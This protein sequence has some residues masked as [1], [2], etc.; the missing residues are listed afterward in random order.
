M[1]RWLLRT[2]LILLVVSTEGVAAFSWVRYPPANNVDLAEAWDASAISAD[3]TPPWV[4]GS[5]SIE[6]ADSDSAIEFEQFESCPVSRVHGACQLMKIEGGVRVHLPGNWLGGAFAIHSRQTST[7]QWEIRDS[8]N[9]LVVAETG[10][11]DRRDATFQVVFPPGEGL[12]IHLKTEHPKPFYLVSVKRLV[13][14]SLG[15]VRSAFEFDSTPLSTGNL[16][17]IVADPQNAGRVYAIQDDG[18]LLRSTDQGRSWNVMNVPWTHTL[19]LAIAPLDAHQLFVVAQEGAYY[20]SDRGV[21]WSAKLTGPI[22]DGKVRTGRERG[23]LQFS[24]DLELYESSDFGAS[25]SR[26]GT[27][28][29]KVADLALVSRARQS[30][31]RLSNGQ[32][33][34]RVPG[35]PW[36]PDPQWSNAEPIQALHGLSGC[37][38]MGIREGQLWTAV[39]TETPALPISIPDEIVSSVSTLGRNRCDLLVSTNKRLL[40]LTSGVGFPTETLIAAGGSI[41]SNHRAFRNQ[42]GKLYGLRDGQAVRYDRQSQRRCFASQCFHS[43]RVDRRGFYV[44]QLALQEGG[45]EG[46]F[47]VLVNSK[48]IGALVVGAVLPAGGEQ[49]GFAS[50]VLEQEEPLR[51]K[52]RE[53]TGNIETLIVEVK[54][55]FGS[56]RT[57]VFGPIES[58]PSV[59]FDTQLLEPGRYVVSVR[60][61]EG[62]PKGRFGI[63]IG[64]QSITHNSSFGGWMDDS[65]E[66]PFVAM[67]TN[68]SLGLDVRFGEYFSGGVGATQPDF[69]VSYQIPGGKRLPYFPP[70]R[71][72]P[73]ALGKIERATGGTGNQRVVAHS[74]LALSGDGSRFISMGRLYHAEIVERW[75]ATGFRLRHQGFWDVIEGFTPTLHRRSLTMDGEVLVYA[76]R[77]P[78]DNTPDVVVLGPEGRTFLNTPQRHND[79]TASISPDGS[80]IWVTAPDAEVIQVQDRATGMWREIDLDRPYQPGVVTAAGEFEFRTEEDNGEIRLIR[81]NRQTGISD[82]QVLEPPLRL[83]GNRLRVTALSAAGVNMPIIMT[84]VE[85][86]P[87]SNVPVFSRIFSYSFEEQRWDLVSKDATGKEL[88]H[89]CDS[90]VSTADGRY[91]LFAAT[92][93][94]TPTGGLR[95]STNLLRKDLQTGKLET[96]AFAH[97]GIS[98]LNASADGQTIVFTSKASNLAPYDTNFEDIF[99]WRAR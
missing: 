57:T 22:T 55:A 54:R 24:A 97:D 78:R 21:T 44:A 32:V 91:V 26:A 12:Q 14:K 72:A 70:Q 98:E 94:N 62:D 73:N 38:L 15:Q 61:K 75:S 79:S 90:P 47:S 10:T 87:G 36:E 23:Y 28:D 11:K 2:A 39:D 35:S 89:A 30:T 50:I 93:A 19:D 86:R 31:L 66:R 8:D 92:L 7:F 17:D 33:M 9:A 18:H 60:S 59:D 5:V 49:P 53:Y 63:S 6:P 45:A 25:I 29:I 58:P 4:S 40:E 13:S 69:S 95:N 20:S 16:R 96:I 74:E 82:E 64:A 42:N 77:W 46:V 99:V 52:L 68:R 71:L 84:L 27:F 43:V 3:A 37:G 76:V 51:L 1:N 41:F 48:P 83:P 34:R 56:Q 80:H 88:E 85:T 81:L 65:D 67:L